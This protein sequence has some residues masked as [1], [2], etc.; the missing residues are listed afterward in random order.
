[1]TLNI[2]KEVS[3]LKRMSV[4]QLRE[5]YEE[6][7][8]EACRTNNRAWLIK[9]IAWRLQANSEGDLSERAR[10]KALEIAN[11]ADLRLNPPRKKNDPSPVNVVTVAFD[12]KRDPRLPI[13]GTILTRK[14]KGE[15]IDV[16]V[17]ADGFEF[18]DEEYK[19]LSA[20]AKHV[21]GTHTSG[22]LFFGLNGKTN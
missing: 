21:T 3:N 10:K 2:G 20:V 14:Y 13:P 18:E 5:R 17:L 1:M 19:S 6:V 15:T 12:S 22:F 8:Q 4:G 11:D 16:K 7:Y 9:R